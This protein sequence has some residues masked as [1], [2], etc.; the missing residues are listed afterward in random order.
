MGGPDASI[1]APESVTGMRAVIAGLKESDSGRFLNYDGT[2]IP[3]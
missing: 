3:W 1:E 2:E